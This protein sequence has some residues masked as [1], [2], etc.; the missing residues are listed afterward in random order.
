[1]FPA[2]TLWDK[3]WGF[4]FVH[5][6]ELDKGNGGEIDPP[7]QKGKE[8]RIWSGYLRPGRRR[9]LLHRIIHECLHGAEWTKDEE[10]VEQ[11]SGAIARHLDHLIEKG[12]IQAPRQEGDD[13]DEG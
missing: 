9:M 4:R 1:M 10:W 3:R 12:W 5:R 7:G 8:I 13:D 11:V 6:R 2:I